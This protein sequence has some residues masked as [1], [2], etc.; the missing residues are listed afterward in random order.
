[1]ALLIEYSLTPYSSAPKYS[2]NRANNPSKHKSSLQQAL[3]KGQRLF[4]RKVFIGPLSS[5]PTHGERLQATGEGGSVAG[6]VA[7]HLVDEQRCLV[8]VLRGV[9]EQ[10]IHEQPGRGHGIPVLLGLHMEGAQPLRIEGLQFGTR[11]HIGRGSR[12]C[13]HQLTTPHLCAPSAKP[14]LGWRNW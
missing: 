8:A 7:E 10:V 1:M 6:Q 4:I 12:G 3:T 9:R 14:T 13:R 2:S 5:I 11:K